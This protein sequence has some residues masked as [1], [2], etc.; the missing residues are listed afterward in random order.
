MMI[1]KITK[2]RTMNNELRTTNKK[3]AALLVVLFVIMAI[4]ILSLGFL[5][6]SDVEMACGQNM[7]LRTKMD[8]LAESGLQHAKGL[9]LNPQ[10]IE[11]EYW[12]GESS[13]QLVAGSGNYY[14][15]VV[16]RDDPNYCNYIIDCNAYRLKESEEVGRSNLRAE[17][18]LDPCIALSV[19]QS[20][21][22]W[23]TVTVYGDVNCVGNLTNQGN[24]YGDVFASN[25]PDSITGITGQQK[26][27][28]ELS[29]TW[30]SITFADITSRY[31]Y[32]PL[33]GQT[34]GP[35][36]PPRVC[37]SSGNLT[38]TGDT[39]INGMLLIVGDLTISGSNNVIVAGKNLPALYVTRDLILDNGAILDVNGLA[40]VDNRVLING[41]ASLNVL[42][43]LFI[44]D[45]LAETT[46][47]SSVNGNTAMLYGPTRQFDGGRDALMFD[48]IDDY[49]EVE[50]ESFFDITNQITVS[51]WIKVNAF[52]RSYQAIATKGN[53]AWR[54]QRWSNTNRIEFACTGLSHSIPYGSLIGNINVND[55]QW[56]HVAGVYDGTRIYLYIDGVQ[57]VN[58]PTSGS[59]NMNNYK[60][61]I[62]EN[63]E[64]TDRY[65]NG[66]ID[67]VQIYN[68]G[69]NI[70]EINII[71]TGETVSNPIAHWKFDEANPNVTIT[72]APVKT[73]ILIGPQ[74]NQ[75]RW[76]QAAGAF[77][78]SIQRR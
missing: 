49:A 51:A 19:G 64:N 41:D 48:G 5:S 55:G 67:D 56:H 42:G 3:G 11:Q 31:S 23:S 50:N 27:R 1:K 7:A 33:S 52:T 22:L 47:D 8:Y 54:I 75:Q 71:K 10:D 76:G 69:L 59:I 40:V 26:T 70:I 16:V 2:L 29:L 63:A 20:T 46:A 61:M 30:P 36:D 78:R 13:Q 65:W 72:A 28:Q 25:P 57:D 34:F 68:R 44:R 38:L 9:I 24:I 37:Y 21:T 66:W 39:H 4:T 62:G 6:R 35:Y 60:V 77:F 18:R 17:L 14:D 73:A 12:I 74:D 15:V 32:G 45:I 43:G 58:T 53:S